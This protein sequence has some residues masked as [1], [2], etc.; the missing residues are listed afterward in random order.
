LALTDER[1]SKG[2]S[3]VSL[4]HITKIRF[5]FTPNQW[6]NEKKANNYHHVMQC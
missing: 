5:D 6:L 1:V 3:S 4:P 2:M